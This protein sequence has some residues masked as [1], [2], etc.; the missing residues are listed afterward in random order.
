MF[1][2]YPKSKQISVPVQVDETEMVYVEA[3]YAAYA[4]A[5]GVPKYISRDVERNKRYK[6]DF[7]Y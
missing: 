3:L 6:K 2:K 5:E 7:A 1:I 4:D